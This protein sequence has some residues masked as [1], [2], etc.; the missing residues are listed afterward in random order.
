MENNLLPVIDKRYNLN[1]VKKAISYLGEGHAKGKI[2]VSV[3]DDS[4]PP[5]Q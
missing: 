3:V 2:S 4:H 5:V 1:Q